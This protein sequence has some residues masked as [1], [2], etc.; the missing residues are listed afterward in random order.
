MR[1]ARS[2]DKV[3][4]K[5]QSLIISFVYIKEKTHKTHPLLQM[6]YVVAARQCRQPKHQ[7]SHGNLQLQPRQMSLSRLI[8]LVMADV[9]GWERPTQSWEGHSPDHQQSSQDPLRHLHPKDKKT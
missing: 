1:E 6:E 2:Q 8:R 9:Q 7:S 5:A 3:L 4:I